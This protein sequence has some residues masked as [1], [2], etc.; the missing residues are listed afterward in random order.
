[1]LMSVPEL[2]QTFGQ[3]TKVCYFNLYLCVIRFVPSK[4]ACLAKTFMNLVYY[5]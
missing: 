1:M 3:A 4:D 2:L 5:R